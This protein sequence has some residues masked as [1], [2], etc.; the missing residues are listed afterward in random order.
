[1]SRPL[2]ETA[3]LPRAVV[4]GHICLDLMPGLGSRALDLRPGALRIVEPMTISTGGSVSNTGIAMHRLGVRT[5]LVALAG[6]D[7]LGGVLRDVLERESPGLGSGLVVRAGARTSYSVI[8]SSPDTDR[9]VL[10]YPGA[11]DDFRASDLT[12]EALHGAELLHVGYPPLMR[13]LCEGD[14]AELEAILLAAHA[15]GIATSLDMAEPDERVG[16]VDWRRLLERVLPVTDIFLPSL[17]E[18]ERM[19]RGS[20]RELRTEDSIPDDATIRGLAEECLS[21]GCA[22]A[23]VKLGRNGLYLRTAVAGRIADLRGRLPGID[24]GAW[25]NRE[26]WS[27]VFEVGVRG[28]TGSGDTTIAGFLAAVLDRRDPV[29]ALNFACAVGSLCVEAD[30]AVSGIGGRAQAEARA[31]SSLAR[32][33]PPLPPTWHPHSDGVLAGP[34]DQDRSRTATID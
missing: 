33:V 20:G 11:N 16:E 30:D 8:L 14:G 1:L 31:G 27:P 26:L 25:S 19:L 32:P 17:G 13:G 7:P 29:A 18:L 3:E 9:I 28:T 10:H 21:F 6:D 12:P 34:N 22:I 4:A 5:R 15:A 23:G 24:A 2:A